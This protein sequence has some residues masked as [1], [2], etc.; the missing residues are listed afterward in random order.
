MQTKNKTRQRQLPRLASCQLRLWQS[1]PINR[2][3]YVSQQLFESSVR[4]HLPEY[5]LD[6]VSETLEEL[7]SIAVKRHLA[8][9]R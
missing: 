6:G 9:L 4:L 3:A 5:R 1:R 8:C 7:V 2:T